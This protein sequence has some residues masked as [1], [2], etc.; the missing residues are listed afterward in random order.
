[1]ELEKY[2]HS[3]GSHELASKFLEKQIHLICVAV[4]SLTNFN[5]FATMQ[6][7]ISEIL[8][9]ALAHKVT[10]ENETATLYPKLS[11]TIIP[12][13]TT[14][15]RN[16]FGNRA[17]MKKHIQD[18]FKANEEYIKCSEMLFVLEDRSDFDY[19]QAIDVLKEIVNACENFTYTKKVFYYPYN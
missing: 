8:A 9:S 14:P 12:L 19:R 7:G 10:R 1:M 13:T 2:I 16:D 5:A 11:M 3:L 15:E 4:N 18:C 17:L 6:G